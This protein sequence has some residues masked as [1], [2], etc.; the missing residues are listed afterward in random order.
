MLDQV[1]LAVLNPVV[2]GDYYTAM[3]AYTVI[4]RLLIRF[5]LVI[6]HRPVSFVSKSIP[7][8]DMSI[9]RDIER[10]PIGNKNNDIAN[11]WHSL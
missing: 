6:L 5:L 8:I 11:I 7:I 3:G 10:G 9:V 1:N 2:R 4:R